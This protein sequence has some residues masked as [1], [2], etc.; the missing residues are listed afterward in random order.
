MMSAMHA[1]RKIT[2]GLITVI[3]MGL[4]PACASPKPTPTSGRDATVKGQH[5][6]PLGKAI[7]KI[8][9]G[10]GVPSAPYNRERFHHWTDADGNG[11]STRYEV[12]IEEAVE[13]PQVGENCRLSGGLWHSYYDDVVTD[14]IGKIHIDHL[15]P[16]SEAWK[17]GASDWTDEQREKFANDLGFMSTLIAVTGKSNMDKSDK[18]P[19]RWMPKNQKCRYLMEWGS[20]KLRYDLAADPAEKKAMRVNSRTCK[21]APVQWIDADKQSNLKTQ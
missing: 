17:S 15:V 12:L 4:V 6:I 2:A 19:A 9:D 11:C 21:R 8:R 5:Q 3:M 10:S 20:V 18:D 13:K 7:D 14:K 16:L 1:N